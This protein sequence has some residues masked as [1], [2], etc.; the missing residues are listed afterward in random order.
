MWVGYSSWIGHT[1]FTLSVRILADRTFDGQNIRHWHQDFDS[2]ANLNLSAIILFPITT[3]KEGTFVLGYGS[4]NLQALI[5]TC[6]RAFFNTCYDEVGPKYNICDD[7]GVGC[8]NASKCLP[9]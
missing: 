1:C 3:L 4:V 9:I 6:W 5:T 2:F 8:T 7:A